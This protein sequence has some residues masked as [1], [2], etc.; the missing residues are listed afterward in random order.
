[1]TLGTRWEPGV[2]RRQVLERRRSSACGRASSTSLTGSP[3]QRPSCTTPGWTTWPPTRWATPSTPICSP[4]RP[5][6]VLSTA[7]AMS[8]SSPVPATSTPTGTGPPAMSSLRSA[9]RRDPYDRRPLRPRRRALDPERGVPHPLGGAQR[10]L[11]RHGRQGLP[12]WR[13]RRHHPDLQPHGAVRRLRADDHGLH[14]R[15]R[16][17]VRGGTQ[18]P[19]Q[20]GS[21]RRASRPRQTEDDSNRAAEP[22]QGPAQPDFPVVVPAVAGSNPVA[23][24]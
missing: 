4:R 15:A 18:P 1:M 21:H 14:R 20:L 10:S 24:P 5:D 11:P 17:Q 8:S 6:R 9:A 22:N 7:P 13:R 3:V 2:R 23:H 12:P 16:L 19:G